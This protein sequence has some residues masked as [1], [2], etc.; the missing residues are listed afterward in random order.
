MEQYLK[1]KNLSQFKWILQNDY[2]EIYEV[3]KILV[4]FQQ[5]IY[6]KS[7]WD[8]NVVI[9]NYFWKANGNFHPSGNKLYH[10][11]K[12]QWLE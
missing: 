6:S 2:P 11:D 4:P 5:L 9:R 8:D 12:K 3:F 7:M 1:T 10:N